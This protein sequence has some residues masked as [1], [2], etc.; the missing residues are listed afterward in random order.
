M[1]RFHRVAAAPSLASA[2][3]ECADR[4]A[5]ERLLGEMA[6]ALRELRVHV[7]H[8]AWWDSGAAAALLEYQARTD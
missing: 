6:G 1:H 8:H 3:A 5:G 2:C 7:P 4:E